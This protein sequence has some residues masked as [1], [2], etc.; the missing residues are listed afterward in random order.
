MPVT[1][2]KIKGI[3]EADLAGNLADGK[4][5]RREEL[6]GEVH[7]EFFAEALRGSFEFGAEEVTEARGRDAA[8]GSEKGE[9]ERFVE[10]SG[11]MVN[12]TLHAGIDTGKASVR[13]QSE[14][15][16]QCFFECV[17]GQI[18]GGGADKAAG[19]EHAP[20]GGVDGCGGGG[21]KMEV[22]GMGCDLRPH[23][24]RAPMGAGNEV[25]PA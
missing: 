3:L 21:R 18:G 17:H 4:V 11:E 5:G 2:G 22:P 24:P 8:V 1:A 16:Y 23:K 12:G 10:M 7:A 19:G 15:P 6:A 14:N 25:G 20:E 13:C 9:V